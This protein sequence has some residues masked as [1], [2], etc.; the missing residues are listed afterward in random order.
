MS[1]QIIIEKNGLY[2]FLR[3][4]YISAMSLLHVEFFDFTSILT[5]PE[6]AFKSIQLIQFP[7]NIANATTIHKLQGRSINNLMVSN[8]SYKPHWMYVALS[9][10][11]TSGGLFVRV[12]LI[13]DKVN[14][15]ETSEELKRM[16][17]FHD[18]CRQTKSTNFNYDNI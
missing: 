5:A 12:P 10:V 3:P 8:W 15:R 17:D 13:F 1:D 2:S 16:N 9:R 4:A 18:F 7:F 14:T 6:R 11:R